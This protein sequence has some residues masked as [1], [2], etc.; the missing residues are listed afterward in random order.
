MSSSNRWEP[1]S[2]CRWLQR[3][4]AVGVVGLI[5]AL[6]APLFGA[7]SS[8][9]GP[10]DFAVY[11]TGSGCGAVTI[12]GN[13]TTD[14]FDSSQGTYAQTKLL[15]KGHVGVTG[16]ATLSG[17]VTINGSL[18]AL[19]PSVGPCR[20][21]APGITLSGKSTTTEGYL[22]LATAPVFAIPPP[23]TPGVKDYRLTSNTTLPPGSYGDISISGNKTLTLAPGTYN[24]NSITLS[25][26][27]VLTVSPPGR[28][29]VNLAGIN[30]SQ[31]MQLSGGTLFNPSGVPLNFQLIYGG[32]RPIA[33]S[34]GASSHAIIYAPLAAATLSGG[35]DWFGAMV[36]GTLTVSGN[37]AIHYDRSLAVRPSITALVSPPPNAAGWNNAN[38][39]VNFTCSDP[40]FGIVSCSPPVQVT[41]EAANQVVTGTAV[42]QAGG[43]ATASVA[44][45]LD[46][47]SPVVT[48]LSPPSGTATNEQAITMSGTVTDSLSGI[49]AITCQGVAATLVGSNFTCAVPIVPGPNVI[50]VQATD[51][52]GN[53]AQASTTVLGVVPTILTVSPSSGQQGQNNLSVV[54]TGL[55]SHHGAIYTF[56]SRHDHG[57]LRRGNHGHLLDGG[58]ADQRHGLAEDR[59]GGGYRRAQC[60]PDDRL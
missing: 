33:I 50:G 40:V 7:D 39:T 41:S 26:N 2:S 53:T 43:T 25:G 31:P 34:G 27:S 54:I 45:N 5:G 46:R 29:I 8:A 30:T 56:R 24:V 22:R 14:S 51:K 57:R 37:M 52:A 28:V 1:R 15:S 49:A 47:K 17:S 59:S 36:V 18:F 12:S 6:G 19:N 16:N 58:F 10:F 13:V 23:V 55:G 11:A 48:I 44:I 3:I 38:V 9:A 42:N 20:A 21:G 60:H 4:I 32:I 35:S